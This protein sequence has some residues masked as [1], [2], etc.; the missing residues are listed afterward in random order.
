VDA[1]WCLPT[2]ALA[3]AGMLVVGC[4][5]LDAR[6]WLNGVPDS[7][8][9]L[10]ALFKGSKVQKFKRFNSPKVQM[11]NSSTVQQLNGVA[12]NGVALNS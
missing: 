12:L 7:Y 8:R 6:C 9:G 3:Q 4:W 2:V 5:I 1:G 11:S 10:E